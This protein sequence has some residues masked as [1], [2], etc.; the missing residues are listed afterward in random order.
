MLTVRNLRQ[1]PE[2]EADKRIVWLAGIIV[3]AL[4]VYTVVK[5]YQ[6][7]RTAEAPKPVPVKPAAE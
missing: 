7:Y 6:N 3:F 5:E 4:F 2:P 1:K